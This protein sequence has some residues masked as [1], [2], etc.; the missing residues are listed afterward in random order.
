MTFY[1]LPVLRSFD[2]FIE[3]Y[4]VPCANMDASDFYNNFVIQ[5]LHQAKT[6][7]ESLP[8]EF[9][10][11]LKKVYNAIN[12]AGFNDKLASSAPVKTLI[13]HRFF[14]NYE[15]RGLLHKSGSASST[16]KQDP[17]DFLKAGNYFKVKN[18]LRT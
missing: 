10:D 15:I 12:T 11:F 9:K 6:V 14:F 8:I 2:D 16:N 5:G 18:L 3:R 1:F 17:A 7:L 4:L 13:F